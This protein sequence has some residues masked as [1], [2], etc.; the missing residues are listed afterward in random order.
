MDAS[1]SLTAD[2]RENEADLDELAASFDDDSDESSFVDSSARPTS[3]DQQR[4][5]QVD[6]PDEREIPMK[7]PGTSA[8]ID[9]Y[10]RVMAEQGCSDLHLT[11]GNPPLYRQDGEITHLDDMESLSPNEV[12]ELLLPIIPDRNY[13]EFL[14]I[15][16]TDFSYE[17]QNVG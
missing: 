3:A 7:Q 5:K 9:R 6:E 11:S 13:E 10:L 14:E 2:P 12:E 1:S 16:D 8:A 4:G 17:I 15:R